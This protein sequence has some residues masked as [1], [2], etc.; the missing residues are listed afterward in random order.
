LSP[1]KVPV[2]KDKAKK[3][4]KGII[5]FFSIFN[6]LDFYKNFKNLKKGRNETVWGKI[7]R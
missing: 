6:G 3:I 1:F 7:G 4:P 5:K 2:K